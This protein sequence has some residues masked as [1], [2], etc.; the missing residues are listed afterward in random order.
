[1]DRSWGGPMQHRSHRPVL[2]SA[3]GEPPFARRA[4]TPL[5]G[6]GYD[7]VQIGEGS[8]PWVRPRPLPIEHIAPCA[9]RFPLAAHS[10][11]KPGY[12]FSKSFPRQRR[13]AGHVFFG[14]PIPEE[15]KPWASWLVTVENRRFRSLTPVSVRAIFDRLSQ[16]PVPWELQRPKCL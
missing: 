1:M 12:P 7:A 8:E 11:L 10:A 6:G 2:R 16:T 5:N 14:N 3:I 13:N 9:A 4:P 15:G